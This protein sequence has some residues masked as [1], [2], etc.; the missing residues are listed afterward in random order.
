MQP[1]NVWNSLEAAKLLASALIP[2]SVAIFGWFVSRR[3]KR[4]E[5]LQWSNQKLIEKRMQIY[6]L[7]APDLNRLLC[8]YVWVG[9]WKSTSP[10]DV[11]KMKRDL[12]RNFNVY[13]HLFEEE[14]FAAYQHFVGLLFETYTGP[15][16]DAKIRSHITCADGDRTTHC[17]YP[18]SPDWSDRFSARQIA[19][20]SAVRASYYH[21][22]NRLSASLGVRR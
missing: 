11:V 7:I 16:S 12:D 9:S 13:R 6:D 20:K 1:S 3:L 21:L 8:F 18:W 15:G 4:L 19:E 22:M 17:T 2:L 14:I 5:L 10:D